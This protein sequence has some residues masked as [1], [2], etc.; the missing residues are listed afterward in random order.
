MVD[1]NPNALRYVAL[2]LCLRWCG[3]LSYGLCRSKSWESC[4]RSAR[5]QSQITERG[6]S[7]SRRFPIDDF[8]HLLEADTNTVGLKRRVTE[9]VQAEP[10]T[11]T[12][13]LAD[14]AAGV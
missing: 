2:L 7:W 8:E 6:T 3:L 1:E 12:R 5:E 9:M 13:T 4:G 14:M 10:A 11:M